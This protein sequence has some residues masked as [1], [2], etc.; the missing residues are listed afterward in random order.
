MAGIAPTLEDCEQCQ[1]IRKCMFAEW[2]EED[3][4][5]NCPFEKEV[6]S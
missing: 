4:L 2:T 5:S 6:K 1:H 3:R